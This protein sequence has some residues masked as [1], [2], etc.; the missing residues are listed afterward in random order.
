MILPSMFGYFKRYLPKSS[1][2][3]GSTKNFFKLHHFCDEANS[4]VLT[5]SIV[6][7][8][9]IYDALELLL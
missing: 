8:F 6:T 3:Q 1:A 2:L 7:F 5:S 9:V 4:A